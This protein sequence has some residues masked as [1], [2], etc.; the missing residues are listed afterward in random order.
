ME[1]KETST[2]QKLGGREEIGGERGLK[3]PISAGEKA[4]LIPDP[5][6]ENPS[7]SSRPRESTPSDKG[8]KEKQKKLEKW[9]ETIIIVFLE[10]NKPRDKGR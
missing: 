1:K 10:N 3:E 4:I 6:H 5:A 7:P 9:G 2:S 8:R